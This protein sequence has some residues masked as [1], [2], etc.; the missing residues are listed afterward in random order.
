MRRRDRTFHLGGR[1]SI[2]PLRA[3]MLPVDWALGLAQSVRNSTAVFGRQTREPRSKG[4]LPGSV[5]QLESHPTSQQGF[6]DCNHETRAIEKEG[7]GK[8]HN[9]RRR[10]AHCDSGEENS[11][12]AAVAQRC[13]RAIKSG[14]GGGGKIREEMWSGMGSGGQRRKRKQQIAAAALTPREIGAAV[15]Y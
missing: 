14:G 8:K 6:E 4:M 1:L 12:A 5:N 15:F 3:I 9:M 13:R 7:E 2:S 11:A 10:V